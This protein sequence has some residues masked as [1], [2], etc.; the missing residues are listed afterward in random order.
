MKMPS[1]INQEE[2]NPYRIAARNGNSL[3]KHIMDKIKKNQSKP[4]DDS[5]GSENTNK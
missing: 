3:P 2:I 5:D 4:K 1:D